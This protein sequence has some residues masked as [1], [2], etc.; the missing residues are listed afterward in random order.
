MNIAD[1]IAHQANARPY[2]AALIHGPAPVRFKGLDMAITRLAWRLA[3]LGVA[4]G[5]VIGITMGNNPAHMVVMLAL[6]RM[7]AVSIPLHGATIISQRRA[8]IENYDVKAV[9]SFSADA[10]IEGIPLIV[11]DSSWMQEGDT[12][13]YPAVTGRDD[14]PWRIMLSS[15]T[16]GV[17]KGIALTHA[18]P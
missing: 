10:K 7:G 15:G 14:Q 1:L 6:A 9:I 8:I 4:P 18:L 5:E 16:T 17:P 13:P 12:A 3:K 2:A 11:I